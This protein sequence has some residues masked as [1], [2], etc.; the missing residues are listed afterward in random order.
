MREEVNLLEKLPGGKVD[1]RP[2]MDE[3][4]VP[5]GSYNMRVTFPRTSGGQIVLY[6]TC[7]NDY[8]ST[9]PVIEVDVDGQTQ[10][11]QSAVLRRWRGQYIIELAREAKQRFA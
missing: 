10:S 7:M 1:V 2:G 11:F 5:D 3:H 9:P 4:G 6:V 8:P